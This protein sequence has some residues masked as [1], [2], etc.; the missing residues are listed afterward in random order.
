MLQ[1]A[2]DQYEISQVAIGALETPLHNHGDALVGDLEEAVQTDK[3]FREA[4]RGI[5]LNGK[6]RQLAQREG[7][8][9]SD[10]L[11]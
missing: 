9:R 6:V 11:N 8:H 5:Y 3:G 7:L 10:P 2:R 4:V 1:M